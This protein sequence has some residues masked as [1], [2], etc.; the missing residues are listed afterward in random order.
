MLKYFHGY[1]ET[2]KIF[3]SNTS[4]NE[5]IP[6]ENFPDYGSAKLALVNV[7][8][9]KCWRLKLLQNEHH[10]T[11]WSGQFAYMYIITMV[12][13]ALHDWW[14]VSLSP[15]NCVPTGLVSV[16]CSQ[17]MRHKDACK[18]ERS[19]LACSV[20]NTFGNMGWH[21]VGTW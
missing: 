21:S 2:T 14:Y 19:E 12:I 7:T 10:H 6:D 15:L 20:Q 5:I 3:L 16:V 11:V 17:V 4:N 1:W 18:L 13:R 8:P 9:L